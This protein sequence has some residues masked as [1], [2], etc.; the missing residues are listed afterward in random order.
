MSDEMMDAEAFEEEP[1]HQITCVGLVIDRS[2]SMQSMWDEALEGLNEQIRQLKE[3]TWEGDE[4]TPHDILVTLI[5]FDNVPYAHVTNMPIDKI[6]D[7]TSDDISPRGMTALHDAMGLAIDEMLKTKGEDVAYLMVTI[8]DGCENASQKLSAKDLKAKMKEC[9]DAGNWTFVFMGTE[10]QSIEDAHVLGISGQ[11]VMQYGGA[12][13]QS[14][15]AAHVRSAR[16]AVS[17]MSNRAKGVVASSNFF[18]QTEEEDDD[19][20]DQTA[21]PR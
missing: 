19:A 10:R 18:A 7:V 15:G 16:G 12:T 20:N 8:T 14:I 5:S 11:N 3:R 17:Y 4:D 13:G 21:Q 9:E 1:G 2:G 6:R